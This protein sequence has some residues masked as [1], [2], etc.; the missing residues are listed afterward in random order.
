MRD[1]KEVFFNNKCL[2]KLNELIKNALKAKQLTQDALAEQLFVTRQTISNYENGNSEPDIETLRK[3]AVILDLDMNELLDI[4]KHQE[5]DND[6]ASY[7]YTLFSCLIIAGIMYVYIGRLAAHY[8]IQFRILIEQYI[9]IYTVI[10]WLIS[11]AAY[12][13][14]I[15]IRNTFRQSVLPADRFR[16]VFRI[17]GI[18]YSAILIL[19]ALSICVQ[20]IIPASAA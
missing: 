8:A 14:A 7:L 20:R 16:Q 9:S 17:G 13:S 3:L 15:L 2:K 6:K 10:P 1:N 19:F 11:C 12:L 4:Q 18:L 5:N